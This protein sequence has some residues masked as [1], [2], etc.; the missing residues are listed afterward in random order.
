[1]NQLENMDVLIAKYILGEASVLEKEMVKKWI[2]LSEE[3]KKYYADCKT[4][5]RLTGLSI[6]D[7][8]N[9]EIAWNKLKH[10]IENKSKSSALRSIGHFFYNRAAV[11]ILF[12]GIGYLFFFLFYKAKNEAILTENEIVLSA[13]TKSVITDT[14]SD[15]SLVK[16]DQKSKLVYFSSFNKENRHVKLT[17]NAHFC[18]RHN[19]QLP[20]IINTGDVFIKD[21][22]TSFSI[23]SNPTDSIVQVFVEEGKVMFYSLN[24]H[25]VE[26]KETETGIYHK[27]SSQF[28][29]VVPHFNTSAGIISLRFENSNLKTVIDTLNK[30]YNTP[31]A[32]FCNKLETLELTATFTETSVQPIVETIAATLGLTI[33]HKQEEIILT[34]DSCNR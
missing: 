25:G 9:V 8:E 30:I 6:D 18:I 4:V 23:K 3:N 10:S 32:L 20:F 5:F 22:G 17:G 19:E 34:D 27:N 14:L 33:I 31:I 29:K 1:M 7:T 28:E 15:G 12:I 16:L 11:F 2:R 13:E 26:L 24:N 21:M